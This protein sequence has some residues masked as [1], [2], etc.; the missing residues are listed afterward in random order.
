M[1]IE[2]V[3]DAVKVWVNGDLVNHGTDAPP[4]R[5]R[6]RLQAEGSEVEFRKLGADSDTR[7]LA[8]NLHVVDDGIAGNG[9]SQQLLPR[10]R[11]SFGLKARRFF[12]VDGHVDAVALDLNEQL[13]PLFRARCGEKPSGI[14][15]STFPVAPAKA[16][17]RDGLLGS[18]S[19]CYRSSGLGYELDL[20]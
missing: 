4:P 13:M 2:C 9:Q 5:A 1:V 6:S 7:L 19:P 12:S 10:M 11:D 14:F 18:L 15:L 20:C 17:P 3:G 8:I 16:S